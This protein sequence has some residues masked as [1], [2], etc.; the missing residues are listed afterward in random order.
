MRVWEEKIPTYKLYSTTA[1]KQSGCCAMLRVFAFCVTLI[2]KGFSKRDEL[3]V[4]KISDDGNVFEL[5][6]IVVTPRRNS[7]TESVV[8][9]RIHLV[10]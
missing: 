1:S 8:H 10:N 2:L 9:S 6:L 7:Y 5:L 4:H 3:T